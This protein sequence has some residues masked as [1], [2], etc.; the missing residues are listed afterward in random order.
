MK[1][2]Y[3][4]IFTMLF[5]VTVYAETSKYE[6]TGATEVESSPDKTEEPV[7]IYEITQPSKQ[8]E[9]QGTLMPKVSISAK[10]VSLKTF[11]DILFSTLSGYTYTLEP[12]ITNRK[13]F[14]SAKDEPLDKLL[15]RVASSSDVFLKKRDDNT[16]EFLEFEIKHYT[17][18][19]PS[20]KQDW[21]NVVSNESIS[22]TNLPS[23]SGQTTSGSS[24]SQG[25]SSL[26]GA[27]RSVQTTSSAIPEG[28][29]QVIKNDMA[30][31]VKQGWWSVNQFTSTVTISAPPSVIKVVD[32]YFLQLEKELRKQVMIEVKVVEVV[33][34]NS[35]E[36][37]VDWNKIIALPHTT[38]A[39]TITFASTVAGNRMTADAVQLRYQ[40]ANTDAII[41]A[42][43]EYGKVNV[44]SQPK[45]L[46]LNNQS[47]II[48][49]TSG[50]TYVSKITTTATEGS[51]STSVDTATLQTGISLYIMP[52]IRDDQ[53]VV[54]FFTPILT[55]LKGVEKVSVGGVEVGLPTIDQ[56]SYGGTVLLNSGD[57]V[58]IGG[59]NT[60][61]QKDI[62]AGIPVLSKI[63]ILGALFG[64]QKKTNE[65]VELVI[66]ITARTIYDEAGE[67]P[68]VVQN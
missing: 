53:K 50:T 63:P 48:Q 22:T 54:L 23:S 16:F 8:L 29:W 26:G 36:V 60:K 4:L 45:I 19:F 62:S 52:R 13:V 7:K 6:S 46:V 40:G 67:K 25:S 35:D 17:I 18:S 56:R 61:R 49:L 14:I 41:K 38:A 5:S 68:E 27:T 3:V 59:L 28:V 24:G 44:I 1:F 11:L 43:G 21:I 32:N 58:I 57:T 47:A 30:N 39:R 65:N 64:Y 42:L 9:P 37:G 15:N 31:L 34:T 66:M 12:S 10:G 51:T 2:V 55:E 33:N 20:I